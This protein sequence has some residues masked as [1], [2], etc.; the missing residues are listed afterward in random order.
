MISKDIHYISNKVP[1]DMDYL[2]NQNKFDDNF[3]EKGFY[4]F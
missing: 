3:D 4:I 1:L 2:Y